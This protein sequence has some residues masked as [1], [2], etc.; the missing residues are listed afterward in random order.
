MIG[1]LDNFLP[2]SPADLGLFCREALGM[3]VDP[4][5]LAAVLRAAGGDWRQSVDL[6]KSLKVKRGCGDG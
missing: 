5:T 4:E 3:D 6:L 2:L 1:A